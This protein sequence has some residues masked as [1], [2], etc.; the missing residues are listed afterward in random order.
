MRWIP[1]LIA[2]AGFA[3]ASE[4]LPNHALSYISKHCLECHDSDSEKGD[5]NLD[6]T[7]VDWSDASHRQIWENVLNVSEQRLMPPVDKDQPTDSEK[8]TLLNWIDK[9]LTEHTPFGGELPRRLNRDEYLNSIRQLFSLSAFKLPAGFP[10]DSEYHGFTNQAE[11]LA[12]SPAL[13]ASYRQTAELVADEIFPPEPNLETTRFQTLEATPEEL[14]LSFSAGSV[15]DGALRLV[16]NGPSMM[17]SC[18]WPTKI[19]IATSGK[20]KL[21]VN[22]SAFKRDQYNFLGKDAPLELEIRARPLN[23]NNRTS[24]NSFRL[25][26]EFKITSDDSKTFSKEVELY[27]GETPVF[28]WKNAP[29]GHDPKTL[30]AHFQDRFEKDPRY[31]AAWIATTFKGGKMIPT[32]PLRGRNGWEIAQKHHNDRDLPLIEQGFEDP[33]VKSLMAMLGTMG[34]LYSLADCIACDYHDNGPCLELHGLKIE[35]PVERINGPAEIRSANLRK[36]IGAD[37]RGE[38]APEKTA[39]RM[40]D[41]L[42]IRAFRRPP[43]QETTDAF[44]AIGE[45]HWDEGYSLNEGLS[46]ILRSILISPRFLYRA[47]IPGELDSHDLS[48]RLAFFLTQRPPT[49]MTALR[50][51]DGKLTDSKQLRQEAL[52]LLPKKFPNDFVDNF[53]SQ[54]LGT[55]KLAEIMPEASFRFSDTDISTAKMETYRFVLEMLIANRPIEDFID[56]DMTFSTIDFV[57]R[58]Y[59]IGPETLGVTEEVAKKKARQFQKLSIPKGHRHGGILGHSA[60]MMATANGV[61]TQPVLRGAWVLENIFGTPVPEPPNNIPALTPDT[62]GATTPREL[63]AAHTSEASCAGCHQHID[64]LGFALENYDPVGRW[65]SKW[66]KSEQAIDASGVMPDGTRIEGPEDLKKWLVENID[67]FSQCVAEK[68]MTYATGRVPNYA[69]RKEIEAIVKVNKENGNRFR[70]LIVDLI[71]SRT[72]RTR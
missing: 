36:R 21:T 23:A 59:K 20:Y 1:L 2:L 58:N 11:G 42:L 16:S 49:S 4:P 61:D 24:I 19:E 51:W 70:D 9:N 65:R 13:M 69:E 26:A 57:R 34:G 3:R 47:A 66:P 28:R 46:Q 39:R 54:W 64:P 17:R 10:A 5:V 68:L 56:P 45:Q 60:V 37:K 6:F 25:I 48:S 18:T 7:E 31:L 41:Y 30:P 71:D 63:L 53:T 29:L 22:A 44:V 40:A 32:P 35:G 12:L 72:F 15:R 14:V 50:A 43:D 27:K 52:R 62:R 38:E 55:G 67:L 8:S 33:R